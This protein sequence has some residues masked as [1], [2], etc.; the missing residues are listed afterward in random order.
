MALEELLNNLP[1]GCRMNISLPYLKTMNF[2]MILSNNTLKIIVNDESA[3]TSPSR[4]PNSIAIDFGTDTT[5]TVVNH[6]I[7]VKR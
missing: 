1:D 6:T 2:T 3:L 7:T 4:C 5:V